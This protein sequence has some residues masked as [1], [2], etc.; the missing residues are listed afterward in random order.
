MKSAIITGSS[1]GIG[2]EITK[3][4]LEM[5]YLVYG[6]SRYTKSTELEHENLVK[7]PC[8]ITDIKKL[9]AQVNLI[10]QKDKFLNILINNA[11]MGAVGPHE[12]LD[13]KRLESMLLLNFVSPIILTRL[14]LRQI[15][16]NSGFIINISSTS[17][18]KPSPMGAAYSATKAG[19][20]Q[21]GNSLFEEVR[22]SGTKVINIHPDTTKT[23]FF[24]ELNFKEYE[25]DPSTYIL[26]ETIAN[27][28][29]FILNANVN[30]VITDLTIKPQR[31][32]LEKKTK[33]ILP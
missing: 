13:L 14:C 9:K 10:L 30:N 26:P 3:K 15:K 1:S 22:K 7:V 29:E 16:S 4:L 21:F 17:A 25:E 6:F 19:I 12:E 31:H 27:L 20:S 8:D 23:D 32:R 28:I 2:L 33:E 18:Q 24:R 5:G 11:G